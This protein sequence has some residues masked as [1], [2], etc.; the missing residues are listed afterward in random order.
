MVGLGD[1]GLQSQGGHG[2]LEAQLLVTRQPGTAGDAGR[3]WHAPRRGYCR[4][5]E[6]GGM[7]SNWYTE[8]SGFNMRVTSCSVYSSGVKRWDELYYV[9]ISG[10]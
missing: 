9:W 7:M 1:V 2:G 5:T 10:L 6:I 4:G 3:G 8:M